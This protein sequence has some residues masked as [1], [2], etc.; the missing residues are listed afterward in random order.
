[1]WVRLIAETIGKH[2]PMKITSDVFDAYLKCPTKCWLRATGDL[3][4]GTDY[5]KWVKEQNASYRAT[6]TERLVAKLANDE[7]ARSP[8]MKDAQAAK[9]RLAICLAL[10]LKLDCCIL[11]T[12]IHAVEHT[13]SKSKS[14]LAEF[15]PIRF[16]FTNKLGKD[17]K[18]LLG[19]DGFLLSKTLGCEIN[20][21]KIIHGN[22]SATLSV[23][24][25]ILA[26]EVRKRIKNIATLLSSPAPPELVLNRHCPECEFRNRCDR[27]AK[28]TDDLSLLSGMSK[29]ERSRHRSK[30]IFTVT[31]LSYN[32]RP[33]RTRK[34]AKKP[35]KPHHLALQALAIRQNTVYIHGTPELPECG[36]RVYLD[37]EGLPDRGFYY[38]IGALVVTDERETFLSLWADTESDEVA[39]FLKFV[40]AISQL[41]DC[42]VFHF[43]NYDA[44]A[45]KRI[46]ASLSE[47]PQQPLS[48]ILQRSVNVLSLVYPHV[49]FPTYSNSLKAIV[50]HLG[51][52]FI[53]PEG[54]GL[55][56]IVWRTQ[57]E[58]TGD[59]TFKTRILEYNKADC[60]ALMRLTEFITRQISMKI[61][62][63]EDGITVNR[64]EDMKI[65]RPHWQLFAA[66]PFALDDLRHVNKSAYFDY[67]REKVFVR[68]HPQFK[69]IHKRMRQK[70]IPP[71]PNKTIILEAKACPH[72]LS[73]KLQRYN[74]SSHDVVDLK[75]S[76]SG[77]KKCT[78]RYVSWR[79]SCGRCGKTFRSEDRLPHPQRYGH[80]LASWCVYQNNV[81]GVNMSKVRKGLEEI[82]GLHLDIYPVESAMDRIA[83]FY[84]TLY[85]D[86]LKE[87]VASPV[88]HIDETTVRMRKQQGYVWV[89]TTMDKVYYFYRPTR[90]TDFLREM[91][92][93][94]RG[95]LVSD[96]YTGYD[97]LPCVQQKCLVHFIRD[98]DDDLLRNPLD[99]ELKSLT[100]AFGRML[101][102]IVNTVDRFGLKRRHLNRHTKEVEGFMR[103]QAAAVFTSELA[104][105]YKKRFERHGSKMFTFIAHDGVPWNNNNAE[106]AIKRFVKYRRENDG[107]YSERTVK[108]YLVLASIFETCEFNN[109]NVLKFLLSKE[110]SL[111]GLL[112]MGARKNKRSAPC[113]D[114]NRIFTASVANRPLS[115]CAEQQVR[116]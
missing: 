10:E 29:K 23:K 25:S 1:M 18:L 45:I 57:W 60:I 53:G 65:I 56:S 41:P 73:R 15:I 87:I 101:R 5:T 109:V 19:F 95:V 104:N 88:I 102:A 67:Q 26:G 59:P 54:T 24:T 89:L 71:K 82:F 22:D 55:D 36:S 114:G 97:S 115:P 6:E 107:R 61:G 46:A 108:V 98:I 110:K 90:E 9:W 103:Y 80:G 105:K 48:A 31:Q 33:R 92:A 44:T 2:A 113:Q 30:G 69:L 66:K 96:S 17:E 93:S 50:R 68:T 75:F 76:R 81:C 99:E 106:H 77:V 37:V 12:E 84:E 112:R 58:K 3:S 111:Q 11:E 35:T 42:R 72:C 79:Y 52:D 83:A 14:K 78:T 43:G 62:K 27:I 32:F 28:A 20:I 7:V 4:V 64:T 94:F 13:P 16:V 85:A 38:L 21:G 70:K 63:S 116:S 51:C 91:L 74:E 8:A 100:E 49:Y 39:I 86:I 47:G 34:R 40:E